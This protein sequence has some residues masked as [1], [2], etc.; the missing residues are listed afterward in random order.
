MSRDQRIHPRVPSGLSV[1]LRPT[2]APG[3]RPRT[4]QNVSLGG[5]ACFSDE[6]IGTGERVAVNMTIGGQDLLL[7]GTV[8][9]CRASGGRF[10]LGLRFAEDAR[11]SRERLCRDLEEIERYRHEVLLL[12]GRQLSSDAAALEW[13]D[14]RAANGG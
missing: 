2:A 11:E 4:I 10:E 1:R 3:A 14:A 5:I 6:P 7:H 12:E 9:W 8:V 13:M